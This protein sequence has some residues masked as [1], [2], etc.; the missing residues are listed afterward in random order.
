MNLLALNGGSSSLKFALYQAEPGATPGEA[1]FRGAVARLGPEARA[2]FTVGRCVGE[3]NAVQAPD[4][5]A[6][7]ALVLA[8]LQTQ[9]VARIDAVGCR[10][11]H[12]GAHFTAPALIDDA[13]LAAISAAS[14]LAPLHNAPA[15]AVIAALRAARGDA[16]PIVAAFDTAFH[17]TL[18]PYAATYAIPYAL[19]ERH[20]IRRFGFHGLA[21]RA[22]AGRYAAL[23]GKTLVGTRLITLQLGNG[24]SAAAVADGRSVETSMGLTPLE[25][26]MMGTRA[27]D[28][29]PALVGI[30]ARAEGVDVAE[31]ERWLN[32][33][34]GLLGVSGVSADMRAVLAVAQQGD[35]RAALAVE[36]FCY[37]A[38]RTIGAYLAVLGGA[39]A[40]VFGG[41]I[42]EHQA[43]VRA[44]ICAEMTWC[45]LA[46]DPLRN[47]AGG[48]GCVSAT[49]APLRAY[50][51]ATDEEAVIATDTLYVL[52]GR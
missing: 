4:Q 10:V 41:G 22:L 28:V 39:D 3:S 50:I 51:A 30:L 52:A 43:E 6:A 5:A 49:D 9:G 33:R 42:G 47:A 14:A 38:R 25:G 29:D 36:M 19:S 37:R 17:R 1:R 21:H 34:S 23:S 44:R 8:W 40:I 45:G 46:L 15:L 16:T 26:L 2:A 31:V 27:G 48:E 7:L 35:Q 11:V 13:V 20:G 24:C 12:G 18:P 32:E